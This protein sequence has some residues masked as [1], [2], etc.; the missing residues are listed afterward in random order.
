[1]AENK[2]LDGAGLGTL[3][4]KIK[5]LFATKEE[6]GN[7]V[8]KIVMGDDEYVSVNGVVSLPESVTS[9]DIEGIITDETGK[10]I[11]DALL[12]LK[13]DFED[14]RDNIG[15]GGSCDTGKRVVIKTADEF[16]SL[17]ADTVYEINKDFVLTGNYSVPEGV[18]FFFA[19]GS[20]YLEEIL[21]V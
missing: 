7:K 10:N 14:I 15:P 5:L 17:T 4:E 20:I 9:E 21:V 6:I 2:Y 3:W 11:K 16:S 1:M 12:D 13:Q 8:E 18:T 19:G